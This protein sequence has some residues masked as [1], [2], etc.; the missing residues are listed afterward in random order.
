MSNH[1]RLIRLSNAAERLATCSRI[2]AE[3]SPLRWRDPSSAAFQ[4]LLTDDPVIER[5][6]DARVRDVGGPK[7]RSRPADRL[8]Q[9]DQRRQG[10]PHTGWCA[11]G[12]HTGII[13]GSR[14]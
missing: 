9:G 13:P 10:A 6:H 3:I 5:R 12:E 8:F 1:L 11:L 2:S 7:V 4:H 14:N